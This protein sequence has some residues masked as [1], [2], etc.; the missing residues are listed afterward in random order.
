MCCRILISRFHSYKGISESSWKTELQRKFTVTQK[1]YEIYVTF[2]LFTKIYFIIYNCIYMCFQEYEN[3]ASGFILITQTFSSNTI[4]S[5][6]YSC[7]LRTHEILSLV[8]RALCLCWA[9]PQSRSRHPPGWHLQHEQATLCGHVSVS[10]IQNC[11]PLV[12]KQQ[13]Q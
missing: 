12:S 1:P 13:T 7:F 3:L 5:V 4:C 9:L 10:K 6:P 11:R 2:L 8:I